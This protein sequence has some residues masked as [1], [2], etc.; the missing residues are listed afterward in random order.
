[1]SAFCGGCGSEGCW[2]SLEPGNASGGLE[3]PSSRT[4]PVLVLGFWLLCTV[5]L[6]KTPFNKILSRAALLSRTLLNRV[7]LCA[8]ALLCVALAWGV[9]G[10]EV[11]R[12]AEPDHMLRRPK[13]GVRGLS[14]RATAP[15]AADT[16]GAL[17]L[18]CTGPGLSTVMIDGTGAHKGPCCGS[19]WV[20]FLWGP[21]RSRTMGE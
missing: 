13:K 14:S 11:M 21:G 19:F 16:P 4:G 2:F 10:L 5:L 18:C 17:P 9:W 7:L 6:C 3:E 20:S 12:W 8:V 1:M 15:A